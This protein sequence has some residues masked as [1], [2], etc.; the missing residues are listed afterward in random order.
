MSTELIRFFKFLTL[1]VFI[2]LRTSLGYSAGGTVLAYGDFESLQKTLIQPTLNEWLKIEP[3]SPDD[4][5][6]H[7]NRE[8][9]T[10]FIKDSDG[11][12]S[13]IFVLD[14]GPYRG[15][16][17]LY[18]K[19]ILHSPFENVTSAQMWIIK[20]ASETN[21]QLIIARSFRRK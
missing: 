1:F 4:F 20:K 11:N 8:K 12:A 16:I 17:G 18:F 15:K 9:N 21:T 5:E 19:N 2:S 14:K 10:T 6:W 7:H 3:K 13:T